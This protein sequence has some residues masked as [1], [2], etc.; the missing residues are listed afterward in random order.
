VVP[1]AK[2][3]VANYGGDGRLL[4][5][6]YGYESL[7]GMVP[8]VLFLMLLLLWIVTGSATP[9]PAWQSLILCLVGF[10]IFCIAGK[11][12]LHPGD[13]DERGSETTGINHQVTA[14]VLVYES[15]RVDVGIQSDAYWAD[16][17]ALGKYHQVQ[18][19]AHERTPKGL[20]DR[21]EVK[22][23]PGVYFPAVLGFGLLLLGTFQLRSAF[24][25][26]QKRES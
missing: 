21:I 9:K 23:G 19:Y 10:G 22:R 14:E 6:V 18:L 3:V 15:I 25:R 2:V 16:Y 11:C 8:A 4:A 12:I 17:R 13:V 20:L 7:P 24:L 5:E 1:W 26:M